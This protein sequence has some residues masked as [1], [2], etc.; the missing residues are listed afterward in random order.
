MQ[1]KK[2][3]ILT[4]QEG[5]MSLAEAARDYLSEI[6][7]TKVRVVDAIGESIFRV[8][9]FFYRYA[10]ALH[11]IPYELGKNQKVQE[12]T[13]DYFLKNK[14]KAMLN[15]L[16]KEKPNLIVTTHFGYLPILD[17]VK[18]LSKFKHINI[19][20]D[21]LDVLP[22]LFSKEADYNIGFPDAIKKGKGNGKNLIATGWLTKKRFF[23]KKNQKEIRNSLH[24]EKKFTLL[25]CGGSEGTNAVLLLL[26]T[27]FFTNYK[28]EIQIIFITGN[29]KSLAAIIKKFHSAAKMINQNLPSI[30]VEGFT[31][32][33]DEFMA[34]SD[35]VIG[36]AGPNLLF[37]AVA[38]EKPF[39]AITHISGQEDGNLKIIK[40]YDLG[41]IA[42]DP[43]TWSKVIKSIV[44]NPQITKK[45]IKKIAKLAAKNKKTGLLL[46]GL[47]EKLLKESES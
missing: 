6:P 37:E 41:W 32:R 11:K 21:P 28:R 35:V 2:I 4:A 39:I 23:E 33:M 15:V 29:N 1:K 19:I 5:H 10:P 25:V 13:K 31:K 20:H 24:L 17:E 43:V 18:G 30:I 27:L 12:M 42:E 38:Q 47:A 8:Y 26:P 22:I 36:K 46:R 45:K 40:R 14:R 9:R 3:L 44:D 34:A 16:K 7:E